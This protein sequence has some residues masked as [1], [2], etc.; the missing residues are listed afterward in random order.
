MAE[1]QI[2]NNQDLDKTSDV[3]KERKGIILKIVIIPLTLVIQA[4]AAYFIVFNFLIENP[5][6]SVKSE[7]KEPKR[8]TVGLFWEIK[9]FVINPAGTQG[10]RFLVLEMGFETYSSKL[11]EEAEGKRIWIWDAVMHLLVKKT[12]DE[13]LDFTKREGIKAE[14]LEAV[15]GKLKNGN[16]EN[17]YFLKYIMQ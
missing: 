5:E 1:E 4:A 15:N 14:I 6:K 17:L 12:P 16:F 9:E 2:Q 7:S 13:L 8:E 3:K 10:R 11:I